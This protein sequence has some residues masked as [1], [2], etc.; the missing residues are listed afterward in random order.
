MAKFTP[1]TIVRL[2]SGGPKMTVG[3]EAT[4][5]NYVN[6]QWFRG[7]ELMSG[8]F[9]VDAIKPVKGKKPKKVPERS[10]NLSGSNG[11]HEGAAAR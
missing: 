2:K 7:K 1:G 11:I 8:Q 10:V 9:A 3:S 5:G 6:C 4:P